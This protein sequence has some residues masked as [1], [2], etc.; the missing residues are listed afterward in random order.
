MLRECGYKDTDIDNHSNNNSNILNELS[1]KALSKPKTQSVSTNSNRLSMYNQDKP[2]LGTCYAQG[3]SKKS[4]ELSRNKV[5]S[6]KDNNLNTKNNLDNVKTVMEEYPL[7]ELNVRYVLMYIIIIFYLSILFQETN[8][9]FFFEET[10]NK[11]LIDTNEAIKF[12][13]ASKILKYV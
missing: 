13:M 9:N 12:S 11:K 7:K 5:L 8:C 4:I 10:P 2:K 1:N 3:W 6:K